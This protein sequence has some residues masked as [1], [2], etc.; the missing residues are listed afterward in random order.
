MPQ[1]SAAGPDV[2]ACWHPS[3]R[4]AVFVRDNPGV[5]ANIAENRGDR[6]LSPGTASVPRLAPAVGLL[7]A[8]WR[9][10]V[11]AHDH[12][13]AVVTAQRYDNDAG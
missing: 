11:V 7:P 10:G 9:I 8:L 12:R 4:N 5:C 6:N 2:S 1:A 3:R 13:A